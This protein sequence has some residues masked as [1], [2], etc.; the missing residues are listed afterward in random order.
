MNSYCSLI[1][2][3]WLLCIALLHKRWGTHICFKVNVCLFCWHAFKTTNT[4]RTWTHQQPNMNLTGTIKLFYFFAKALYT[5]E[6]VASSWCPGTSPCYQGTF[7][8]HQGLNWEPSTFKPSPWQTELPPP[9]KGCGGVAISNDVI[10]IIQVPLLNKF[11]YDVSF[12]VGRA[13]NFTVEKAAS[14]LNFEL[15]AAALEL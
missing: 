13:L 1:Q 2:C 4:V 12:L 9:H 8:L 11:G 14:F 15:M 3:L 5:P 7:Y 10:I 6:W